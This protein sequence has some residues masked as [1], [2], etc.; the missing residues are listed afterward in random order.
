[1]LA[2]P[3]KDK[4]GCA[5]RSVLRDLFHTHKEYILFCVKFVVFKNIIYNLLAF[6]RKLVIALFFQIFSNLIK[7]S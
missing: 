6:I 7:A 3:S 2:Q 5:K 1:M 4:D